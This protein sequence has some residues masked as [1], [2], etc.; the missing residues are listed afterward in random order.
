MPDNTYIP[1]HLRNIT[2]ATKGLF[3][4]RSLE[5]T[6]SRRTW[7]A[8]VGKADKMAEWKYQIRKMVTQYP[9][10]GP[11]YL[12]PSRAPEGHK[13]QDRNDGHAQ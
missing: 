10:D 4:P 7:N 12:S 8:T 13:A 11:T 9:K 6:T 1:W 2:P 3:S 5:D